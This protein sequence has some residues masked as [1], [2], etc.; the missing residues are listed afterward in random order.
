MSD[1]YYTFNEHNLFN[2]IG[3][4]YVTYYDKR[5]KEFV[6]FELDQPVADH[7]VAVPYAESI[8]PMAWKRFWELL[9]DESRTLAESFENKHGFFQFLNET[10]LIVFYDK[11]YVEAAEAFLTEWEEENNLDISWDCIKADWIV[12]N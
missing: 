12:K 3:V 7:Y 10:G 2:H 5:R 4:Q 8:K 11:A 9:D 1:K 6:A